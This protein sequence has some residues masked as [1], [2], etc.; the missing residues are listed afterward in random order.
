MLRHSVCCQ[1]I[2]VAQSIDHDRYWPGMEE[3]FKHVASNFARF[4]KN[5]TPILR[6]FT[7]TI[8]WNQWTFQWQNNDIFFFVAI[9][10]R[11]TFCFDE[12]LNSDFHQ[13]L[14]WTLNSSD[15]ML[16]ENKYIFRTNIFLHVLKVFYS[17][18]EMAIVSI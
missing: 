9:F 1:F 14:G 16:V 7:G 10:E 18:K 4:Y 2:F 11:H 12:I 6:D 17:K 3:K 15:F 13:N 5:F 8:H